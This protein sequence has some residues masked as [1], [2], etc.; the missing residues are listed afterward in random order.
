MRWRNVRYQTPMP[1]G[2]MSN[3]IESSDGR[4]FVAARFVGSFNHMNWAVLDWKTNNFVDG[5]PYRRDAKNYVESGRFPTREI[6]GS[7]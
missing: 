1:A 6:G 3:G 5:F 2:F 7:E 4:F